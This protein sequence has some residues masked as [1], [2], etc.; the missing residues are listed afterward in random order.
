MK[1]RRGSTALTS[2]HHNPTIV[3]SVNAARQMIDLR[4]AIFSK[5][6]CRMVISA[7]ELKTISLTNRECQCTFFEVCPFRN[8]LLLFPAFHR[9]S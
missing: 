3:M 4:A 1:V 5:L 8:S 9:V 7:I 2:W 6:A